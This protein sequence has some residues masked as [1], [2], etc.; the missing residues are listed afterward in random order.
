MKRL[1]AILMTL[2]LPVM[3]YHGYARWLLFAPQTG[4]LT[5][6]TVYHIWVNNIW[7]SVLFACLVALAI[8][9]DKK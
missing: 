3:I 5:R 9:G 1:H 2:L 8:T 7:L 4:N 6:E